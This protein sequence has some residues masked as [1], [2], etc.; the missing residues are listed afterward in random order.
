MTYRAPFVDPREHYRR[1][2]TEIDAAISDALARGDLVLRRQLKDFEGRFADFV[3]VRYVV[4]L[5]S[6]YHALHF[7]LRAAGIG[8]GDE[9]I[10]VAHTFAAT[11]SAIVHTG[12]TPVLVDVAGDYNMEPEAFERAITARTR[13]VIPVHLNGRVCEMDRILAIASRHR[14]AVVED[15]AQALGATFD[16]QMAGSFGLAGCFS[17]Y[18]FKA[19]GGIGDG[20]AVTTNDPDV[21]RL[22]TLLRFNGEDRETG[23]FHLH[24][25]TALLDNVNAAVLDVK[26]RHLPAWIEHRRHI[27]SLYR[28][29]LTGVG[30]LRLPHFSE[31][32]H[33][34]SFQN[35]VIR[36]ARRDAL[37]E[38]L[39]A[40][41]VETLLHWPKP[42]W[43]HK[44]LGLSDPGL[45]ET[46]RLCG[47]VLSLPMS[48]ETTPEH[49][50]FT[51]AAI[52]RFVATT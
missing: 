2:K 43:E 47:E 52:R 51:S 23:E 39:T 8:P 26:L 45:P 25:Y 33:H 44:G 12:A 22:A 48:A 10:T 17:F 19:L 18:P 50:V 6:G 42:M 29:Q 34:D 27:A 14:L 46:S 16:G 9:V 1:L 21:A 49:V 7:S 31:A 24:G 38:F 5:N 41:G 30:D 13:A 15:A 36:T 37:R 4:G 28:E 40:E 35:Y 11:V 20:G 32:R 3:G